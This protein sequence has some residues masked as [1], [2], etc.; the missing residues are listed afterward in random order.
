[1]A[2]IRYHGHNCVYATKRPEND[3]YKSIINLFNVN[4][5]FTVLEYD[6]LEEEFAYEWRFHIRKEL[7][8]H[9]AVADY[10][11][12]EIRPQNMVKIYSTNICDG[13]VFT[14]S[15]IVPRIFD[16][17]NT[18][19]RFKS[20]KKNDRFNFQVNMEVGVYTDDGYVSY[21]FENLYMTEN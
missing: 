7:E 3:L 4:D 12:T 11:I 13:R 14:K 18:N 16:T 21:V 10:N 20:I 15:I 8:N 19:G 9:L 17:K 5:I 6:K 1:M 2:K